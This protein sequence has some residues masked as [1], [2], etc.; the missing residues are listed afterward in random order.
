MAAREGHTGKKTVAETLISTATILRKIKIK[1]WIAVC[2]KGA[3][4]ML[5]LPP[6]K[7]LYV[8]WFS[9]KTQRPLTLLP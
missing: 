7:P 4:R 3:E 6:M 1:H 2:C 8:S 5:L 9:R